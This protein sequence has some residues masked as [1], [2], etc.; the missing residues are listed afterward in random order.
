MH[1]LKQIRTHLIAASSLQNVAIKAPA[2]QDVHRS[3]VEISM[4]ESRQDVDG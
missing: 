3:S 2:A 4:P 1:E